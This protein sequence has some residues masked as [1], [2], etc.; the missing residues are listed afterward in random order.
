[1]NRI[2]HYFEEIWLLATHNP[3]DFSQYVA[4]V[5]VPLVIVAM[6]FN[7]RVRQSFKKQKRIRNAK[8]KLLKKLQNGRKA[9]DE[10]GNDEEE[11]EEEEDE[12]KM[13]SATS[14]DSRSNIGIIDKYH[15]RPFFLHVGLVITCVSYSIFGAYLFLTIEKPIE[16]EKRNLAYKEIDM[17]QQNFFGNL[18]D[19][20]RSDYVLEDYTKRLLKMFEDVH[21][22]KTYEA[23]FSESRK[24]R[25]I[26]TF[27]SALVF[28]TTTV[29][30]VGYGY[31]VPCSSYGRTLLII[32]AL[33]GIPLTLV[34]MADTGKIASQMVSRYFGDNLAIPAALFVVLLFAYPM[35]FALWLHMTSNITFLDGFY[36]T[37][38]SIF[39]IGFG[40]VTPEINVIHLI[41]FV[42]IGVILVTIT[43]D[44]VA[45]ELIDHVHYMGRHVGK[46]KQLAGKMFQLA[47]SL[48]MKHGLATGVGQ[49]HA[50]A[51]FG[52][53]TGKG[54]VEMNP[55]PVAFAPDLIDG[56]D[57]VDNSSIYSTRRRSYSPGASARH[58]FL[59]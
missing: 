10:K 46:A 7:W 54:N 19:G 24:D 1:M 17:L 39:T 16:Q 29:I 9:V 56:I 59:S 5:V 26:W 38:T 34:T 25:Q 36:F 55:E 12:V 40:D 13:L 37:L 57:F 31:I 27:E 22:A 30:P 33:L 23:H 50:L 21:Y 44:F 53:I 20:V 58:L 43:V 14:K 45:V 47:Q 6:M 28:T 11:E 2:N 52:L 8:R 35:L 51:R 4:G 42:V 32:Y 41:F 15:L 18:T 3:Y 49:L 48:N